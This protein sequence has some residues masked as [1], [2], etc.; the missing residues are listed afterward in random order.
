MRRLAALLAVSATPWLAVRA[1]QPL[2][3]PIW[4]SPYPTAVGQ[5]AAVSSKSIESSYTA[6][7]TAQTIVA[8]YQ[9]RAEKAGAA[10]ESFYDGLGTTMRISEGKLSCVIRI[11]EEE[12]E[13]GSR[14]QIGCAIPSPDSAA[15]VAEPAA[16]PLPPE[17]P[18]RLSKRPVRPKRARPA[19][20][21]PGMHEVEF[22]VDGDAKAAEISYTNSSGGRDEMIVGLPYSDSIFLKGGTPVFL[23]ARKRL[24][25][26]SV[27]PYNGV[28]ADGFSGTVHVVIRATGTVLEEGSTSAPRGTAT[29]RGRVP[30]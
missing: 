9:A 20:E 10:V 19:Q 4:L 22:E 2:L 27:D 1:D 3:V 24:V 29:V 30:R 12:D 16:V 7:V 28:V 18:A 13:D 17:A 14:V 8:H 15:Q 25:L 6:P 11:G 5:T 21:D 26:D 23:S